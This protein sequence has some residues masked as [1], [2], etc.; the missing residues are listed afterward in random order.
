MRRHEIG[1]A[2][3]TCVTLLGCG[4]RGTYNK[5]AVAEAPASYGADESVML[6]SVE[7]DDGGGGA[8]APPA[9]TA[10]QASDASA[11]AVQVQ[12]EALVVEGWIDLEVEDAGDVAGGLRAEVEKMGGRIVSEQES[13]A[14]ESWRASLTIR[15]P[16]AQVE[17]MLA[18]ME[19]TG[20][21]TSKRI[22]ATDVSRTLFDQEIALG[23]L[24]VTLDRMRKLLENGGLSMQDILAI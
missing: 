10:S 7:S 12:R 16:P 2:L 6:A 13:G 19:A 20:E 9:P 1:L 23:N 17:A 4:A 22:Q 8:S 21:I 18:W 11:P 24:R 15:L 3:C 5:A 14:A